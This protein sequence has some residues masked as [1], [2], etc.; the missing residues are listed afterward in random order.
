MSIKSRKPYT[1]VGADHLTASVHKTGDELIGFEYC[2][3]ISRRSQSGSVDQWFSPADLVG[4]T[5]LIRVLAAELVSD[6]CVD[7]ATRHQLRALSAALDIALTNKT[8]E[9]ACKGAT[10]Q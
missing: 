10:E 1:F 7:A 4:L 2:I 5:K 9:A 8:L 6:G 3:T